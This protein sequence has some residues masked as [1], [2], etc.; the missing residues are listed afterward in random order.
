MRKYADTL[1]FPPFIMKAEM[2]QQNQQQQAAQAK[3]HANA[4]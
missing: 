3:A 4:F 2:H 1:D